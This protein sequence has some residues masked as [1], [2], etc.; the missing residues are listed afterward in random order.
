VLNRRFLR[1]LIKEIIMSNIRPKNKW[2]VMLMR[3]VARF[4]SISWAYWTL[5]I[6]WFVA[7]TGYKEGMPKA[8]YFAIVFAASV[9]LVGAAII[10]GVWGKEALGGTVL[11]ADCVLIIIC[12][13]AS[14]HI[15]PSLVEFFMPSDLPFNFTM[16]LPPL[17]AGA[18]FIV[19]HWLS[20]KPREQH[21]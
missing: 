21:V 18:L 19:C 8:L 11:L 12:F 1:E 17:V 7:G 14:P 5:F 10:A 4:L 15:R 6:T 16:V 13:M 9:L 2:A 20:K 3:W